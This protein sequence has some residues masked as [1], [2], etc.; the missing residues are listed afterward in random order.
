MKKQILQSAILGSIILM[1][2]VAMAVDSYSDV[3]GYEKQSFP[4]GTTGGLG[5]TFATPCLKR[6][7]R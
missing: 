5:L 6:T 4:V 3:V 1:N 2:G 7:G